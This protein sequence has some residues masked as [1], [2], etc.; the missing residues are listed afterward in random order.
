LALCQLHS[1]TRKVVKNMQILQ[2][3]ITLNDTGCREKLP[4]QYMKTYAPAAVF[5]ETEVASISEIVV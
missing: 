2:L 4:G 5:V 1:V 3:L